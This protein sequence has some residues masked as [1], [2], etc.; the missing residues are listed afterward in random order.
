MMGSQ[1]R[2]DFYR[3]LSANENGRKFEQFC[4]N[5]VVAANL[6]RCPRSYYTLKR[7]V[8]SNESPSNCVE[9][10]GLLCSFVPSFDRW[11]YTTISHH[12]ILY[13]PN[14]FLTFF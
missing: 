6:L 7:G 3:R 11:F 13:A 10:N 2:R 8:F 1:G 9:A 5:E 14:L 4:E 12:T